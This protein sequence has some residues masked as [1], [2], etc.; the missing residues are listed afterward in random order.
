MPVEHGETERV[1]GFQVELGFSKVY[2]VRRENKTLKRKTVYIKSCPRH[3]SALPHQGP[4]LG[5]IHSVRK[6]LPE[7]VVEPEVLN[8]RTRSNWESK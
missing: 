4:S 5:S 8:G 1:V 3:D 6:A 2:A 7:K